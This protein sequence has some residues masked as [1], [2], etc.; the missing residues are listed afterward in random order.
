MNIRWLLRMALWVRNP[1]GAAK[2]KFI[3]G[4]IAMCLVIVIIEQIWGWPEW[5]TPGE[6]RR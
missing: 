6:M 5:L 4:I 3:F 1:P 2:V